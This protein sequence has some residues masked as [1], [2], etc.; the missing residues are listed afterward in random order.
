MGQTRTGGMLNRGVL[1]FQ[2]TV[3]ALFAT[4]IALVVGLVI[5]FQFVHSTQNAHDA[6]DR[7]I[8]SIERSI[9]ERTSSLFDP[10]LE[11]SASVSELPL[12]DAPPSIQTH[13]LTPLFLQFLK[14]NAAATSAYIRS[15]DGSFFQILNLDDIGNQLAMQH[16]VAEMHPG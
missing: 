5:A 3:L 10:L 6:T 8:D 15:E 2:L 13:P 4:L 14:H 9:V 12:I 1:S 11:F 7:I 16:A